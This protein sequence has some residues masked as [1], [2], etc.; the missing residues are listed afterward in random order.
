[1]KN[2]YYVILII[3][4]VLLVLNKNRGSVEN[5]QMYLSQPTKC[6][7]CERQFNNDNKWRAQPSKCFDCERELVGRSGN[8]KL[9]YMAQPSKCFDCERQNM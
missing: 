7:S 9:G 2:C 4:F 3:V 6:F 8:P 5:F 1:M